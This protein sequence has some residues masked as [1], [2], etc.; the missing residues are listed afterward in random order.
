MIDC[1]NIDIAYHHETN[2][3]YAFSLFSKHKKNE[4][5][6]NMKQEKKTFPIRTLTENFFYFQLTGYGG[7]GGG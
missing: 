7:R 1:N 4:Y 6:N 2:Y 5:L 3:F